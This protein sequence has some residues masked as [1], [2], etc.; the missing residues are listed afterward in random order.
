[1]SAEGAAPGL[2]QPLAVLEGAGEPLTPNEINAHLHL[3]SG[4]VT[5]LLDRLVPWM[6]HAARRSASLGGSQKP[7]LR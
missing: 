3:T 1:M 6:G 2:D 4:S 7:N 5:S